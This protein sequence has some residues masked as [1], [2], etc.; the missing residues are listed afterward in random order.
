M[1]KLIFTPISI[2]LAILFA[3]SIVVTINGLFIDNQGGNSLGGLI[4]LIFA[5]CILVALLIEQNVIKNLKPKMKT[6]WI[7]ESLVIFVLVIIWAI[8]GFELSIG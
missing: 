4:A 1:R 7:W 5:I 2:L 6:V 8:N 3:L